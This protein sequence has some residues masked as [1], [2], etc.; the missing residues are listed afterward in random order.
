MGKV[1]PAALGVFS[2]L[3]N[4]VVGSFAGVF[5]SGMVCLR[6]GDG[7]GAVWLALLRSVLLFACGGAFPCFVCGLLALPLCGAA[8]T[9]LC[10]RK[11][12]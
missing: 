2:P 4:M 9:F 8:P 6:R 11:E 10:R 3:M 12:K 7:G 5:C 1:L